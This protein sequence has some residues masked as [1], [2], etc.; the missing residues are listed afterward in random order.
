MVPNCTILRVTL[1]D[2]DGGEDFVVAGIDR[3]GTVASL[4]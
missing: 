3:L 2:S 4:S 1:T